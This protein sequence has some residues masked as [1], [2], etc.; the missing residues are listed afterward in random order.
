MARPVSV[1]WVVF[2]F[3]FADYSCKW[4]YL[5]PAHAKYLLRQNPAI[6]TN[7]GVYANPENIKYV[8]RRLVR[9]RD[10]VMPKTHQN[11]IR[12]NIL[13]INQYPPHS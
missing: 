7:S 11:I 9:S 5:T 12:M 2:V 8:V 6:T 13:R 1:P 10:L 3:T 4:V